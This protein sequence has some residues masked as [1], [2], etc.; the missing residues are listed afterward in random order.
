VKVM[1]NKLVS[2]Y[3][4]AHLDDLL[5]VSPFRMIMFGRSGCGKTTAVVEVIKL[6]CEGVRVIFIVCPSF[7][8]QLDSITKPYARLALW[9]KQKGIKLVVRKMLDRKTI[10]EMITLLLSCSKRKIRALVLL[11]DLSGTGSLH[12]NNSRQNPLTQLITCIR[13]I[14]T[15]LMVCA[16]AI[17]T[18][19]PIIREN[20]DSIVMFNMNSPRQYRVAF[21]EFGFVKD[22]KEFVKYFEQYTHRGNNNSSQGLFIAITNQ[23]QVGYIVFSSMG[24]I[25][26]CR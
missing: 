25:L 7:V 14:D 4:L 12:A 10:A 2:P 18:V 24:D 13:H 9:A 5:P 11:D 15:S 3:S 17:T 6:R 8:F 16:H 1:Q 21:N 22:Y 23:P 26:H 19:A 20:A